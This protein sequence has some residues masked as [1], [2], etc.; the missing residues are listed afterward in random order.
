[1]AF[2][3]YGRLGLAHVAGRDTENQL[4]EPVRVRF[5]LETV[6]TKEHERRHETGARVPFEERMVP[7]EVVQSTCLRTD[8]LAL[9]SVRTKT[10]DEISGRRRRR[11]C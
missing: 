7:N 1:M 8:N 9:M 2:D 3:E 10:V 6:Q 5:E 4:G 11:R